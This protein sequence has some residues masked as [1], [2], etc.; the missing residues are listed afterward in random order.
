MTMRNDIKLPFLFLLLLL[1]LPFCAIS[2]QGI[3]PAPDSIGLTEFTSPPLRT[4]EEE[5]IQTL[6]ADEEMD[7]H[8]AS[9]EDNLWVQFRNWLFLQLIRLFGTEGAADTL[10]II[11]YI[12]CGLALAYAV[13]RLL[14]VEVSGLFSFRK[15]KAVLATEEEEGREN[16]HEIDFQAAIAEA[17]KT[18]EYNKAVRLLYLSALKELSTRELIH[19]QPG[20]TN[21]QYQQELKALHLQAPFRQLGHFFEY[22]WYGDFRMSEGHYQQ[23]EGMYQSLHQNLKGG[24]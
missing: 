19:W 16:I 10:E 4:I 5:T 3:S 9:P 8:F 11:I 17:L 18:Q 7:Y 24:A 13:L 21:Y 23:A 14:K 2:D 20:K 6:Q 22:A 12:L 15:G 1:W